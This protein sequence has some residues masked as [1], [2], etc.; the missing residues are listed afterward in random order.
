MLFEGKVLSELAVMT[1]W[2]RTDKVI[3]LVA[4][5]LKIPDKKIYNNINN[6]NDKCTIHK[7]TIT[8]SAVHQLTKEA[9]E[10]ADG[11]TNL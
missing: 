9:N 4:L 2:R 3:Y 7:P 6:N 5:H 11:L 10:R 8:I 1:D